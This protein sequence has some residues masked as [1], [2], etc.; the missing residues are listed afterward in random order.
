MAPDIRGHLLLA[1]GLD[2]ASTP[3]SLESETLRQAQGRLWQPTE[4]LADHFPDAITPELLTPKV[5]T[6]GPSV[7]A[8]SPG[9]SGVSGVSL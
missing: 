6:V 9:L 8:Y 1:G 5:K 3:K 7:N 2:I 4:L